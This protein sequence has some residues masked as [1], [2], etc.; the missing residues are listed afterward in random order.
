ML[1]CTGTNV[2][3]DPPWQVAHGTF[4]VLYNGSDWT[5]RAEAVLNCTGTNTVEVLPGQLEHGTLEVLYDG[6]D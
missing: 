4:G 5:V 1:G 6:N 3:E 2:V